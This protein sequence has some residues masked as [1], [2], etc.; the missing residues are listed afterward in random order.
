[1]SIKVSN[2]HMNEALHL[3]R[4]LA[5]KVDEMHVAE[6]NLNRYVGH[7]KALYEVPQGWMLKDWLHGFEPMTEAKDGNANG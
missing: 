7:M 6:N 1:M 5:S 4:E 2:E 3:E